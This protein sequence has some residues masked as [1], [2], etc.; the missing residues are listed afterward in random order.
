MGMTMC[1][2]TI[3]FTHLLT[4]HFLHPL[5]YNQKGLKKVFVVSQRCMVDSSVVLNYKAPINTRTE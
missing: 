5:L 1:M 2:I 4:L 3:D